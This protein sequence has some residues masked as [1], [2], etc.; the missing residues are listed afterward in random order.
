MADVSRLPRRNRLRG[1]LLASG[2]LL[3]LV[4]FAFLMLPILGTAA[5]GIAAGALLLVVGAA[6]VVD[7][8]QERERGWGWSVALG[9]LAAA[10]GVLFLV[11]PLEGMIG[12][13]A[14][15]AGYLLVAGA[16]RIVLAGAWSPV[17]GWGWMLFNGAISLLLGLLILSG[18][19]GTGLWTVGVFLGADALL[20]GM[21]RVAR[22][23]SGWD[24]PDLRLPTPRS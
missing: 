12:F 18:W 17:P 3:V 1:W 2:V 5:A 6:Q 19:P 16:F 8:V 13:T 22:A 9:V 15:L 20:A 24:W 10:A 23:I 14:L 21:S 4:A 7:A 11:D